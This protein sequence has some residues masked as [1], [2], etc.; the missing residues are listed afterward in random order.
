MPW[1]RGTD[2]AQFIE[3]IAWCRQQFSRGRWGYEDLY[4]GTSFILYS[5]EDVVL[6]TLRWA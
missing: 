6:F 1:S 3:V 2:E 5:E 4:T